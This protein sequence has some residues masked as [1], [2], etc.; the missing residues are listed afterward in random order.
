MIASSAEADIRISTCEGAQHLVLTASNAVHASVRLQ[1][2]GESGE[3][4]VTSAAWVQSR[5]SSWLQTCRGTEI[6]NCAFKAQQQCSKERG[7]AAALHCSLCAVRIAVSRAGALVQSCSLQARQFHGRCCV[8]IR[9]LRIPCNEPGPSL[10]TDSHSQPCGV[11]IT[12]RQIADQPAHLAIPAPH[13]QECA[14]C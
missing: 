13:H 3:Q 9:F 2:S 8:R 10:Q 5:V 1:P 14:I 6:I 12:G 4:Y 7:S 11:I